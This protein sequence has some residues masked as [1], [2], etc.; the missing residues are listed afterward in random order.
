MALRNMSTAAMI[1]LT[2]P[3]VTGGHPE[4]ELLLSFEETKALLG[5]VG[6]AHEGLLQVQPRSDGRLAA[7]SGRE[8]CFAQIVRHLHVLS[9]T[10]LDWQEGEFDPPL[11]WS[12]ERA[13]TMKTYAAQRTFT[14]P[15]G[16]QRV[17]EPHS[18][19][20]V[21]NKRIHFFPM[22]D[23]R[24]VLVGHVGDHLPTTNFK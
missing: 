23:T 13:L 4:R 3:W 22:R 12:G 20:H 17:F 14:C 19:L 24:R 1:S 8:A 15:D 16:A 2:Q 21:W 18:K 9:R 11:D 5:R 10:A 7:L 6:M